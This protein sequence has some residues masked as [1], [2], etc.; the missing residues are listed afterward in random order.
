[1][2]YPL[3]K[4]LWTALLVLIVG[5]TT[6][7][8]KW[9]QFHGDTYSQGFQPINSGFALSSAWV[10][11]PYKITSSSPV[12]GKDF[13]GKEILY[14]GTTEA[15]LIAIDTA[16]GSQK[17][18]RYLGGGSVARIVSS[19]AVSDQRDIYV[20]TNRQ[21]SDGIARSTLH[22]VDEF[23]NPRWSYT[24]PD[25]G[26]TSGSP[27]VLSAGEHTLIFV[28]VTV[29]GIANP[30]GELFVLQDDDNQA[31]LL[32]RKKLGVCSYDITGNGPGPGD[33]FDFLKDAWDFISDFPIEFDVGGMPLPDTFIAPTAAIDA[34]RQK[35]LIAIADNLCSMGAY[36]W[37]G[38][39]LSVVWSES[40]DFKKHSST[41]LLPNGLMVFGR[42]DGKVFAFD[43]QTGVKM[44]EYDAG[45]PA[46]ATPAAPPG[47]FVFVVSKNHIQVVHAADG[48]L[49]QDG[50]LLRKLE[51]LDQTHSS[52]AVTANRVYVSSGEMLTVTYDLKTRGHD[53][54]FRGNG[55]SSVAVGSKGDVYAVGIDGTIRKYGGTD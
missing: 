9:A 19:P 26:F 13:E 3:R 33:L 28:Y 34:N 27:K 30:Q 20:I 55:L 48:T 53:S 5:C 49:I 12:L 2:K 17:W 36:E 54:N 7:P 8:T 38:N 31:V 42:K 41:A 47:Q 35:P 4:L 29:G 1:M 50:T 10:S 6:V 18:D 40:H 39:D 15:H 32:D 43:V 14:V 11:E 25:D 37:D 22:K 51:L 45:E 16:D 44:W 46:F 23:S 21:I 24:F 52:P